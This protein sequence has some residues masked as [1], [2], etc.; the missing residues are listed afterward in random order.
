VCHPVT[1]LADELLESVRIDYV[2][3]RDERVTSRP[4]LDD[5]TLDQLS[6]PKHE[7]LH[8]LAR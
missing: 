3:I 4:R 8:G 1:A 6:Q 5:V 2:R 7:I